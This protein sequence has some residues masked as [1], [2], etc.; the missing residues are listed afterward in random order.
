[1]P[2]VKSFLTTFALIISPF[3]SAYSQQSTAVPQY[4]CMGLKAL[5]NGEGPMPPP[6]DEY[7]GPTPAATPA[8]IA[9]ATLIVDDPLTVIDGR[10]RVIRPNGQLVWIDRSEITPWHVVS[11][12]NAV[13]SV[14]ML[15]NGTLQTTSH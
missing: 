15:P 9:S 6:V 2:P 11:N 5:W 13:C 7:T 3:A 4:Q 12:P 1:M 10:V 14:I 8:G